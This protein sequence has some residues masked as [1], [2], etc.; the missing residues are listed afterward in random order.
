[1]RVRALSVLLAAGSPA[2]IARGAVAGTEELE[3]CRVEVN[4]ELARVS[5]IA[6]QIR[7]EVA[8][9]RFSSAAQ[10]H[11]LIATRWAERLA[12]KIVLAAND[13]FIPGRVNFALR[14]AT[15]RDLLAFLRVLPLGHVEGE[16]ANGH[17]RATGGSVPV[18]EFDRLLSVLA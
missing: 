14:S 1:M 17:P 16:F 7:R 13:G 4:A 10:I 2:D 15:P 3:A 12:P 11:P 8:I 9:I 18:S 6:P 5:R